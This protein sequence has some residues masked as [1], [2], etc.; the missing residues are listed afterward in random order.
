MDMS[1][2]LKLG[3]ALLINRLNKTPNIG[4]VVYF[5]YPLPDSG[6]VAPLFL[7]RCVALP[8]DSF[9]IID[10]VIWLNGKM[11]S[12]NFTSKENYYLKLDKCYPDSETV[13]R[14]RLKEGGS[15]SD[16]FDYSY[17]LTTMQVDSLKNYPYLKKIERKIEKPEI[18]DETIFPYTLNYKWNRDQF[19]ALYVPKKNDT[20][21]LDTLNIQLYET[22]ITRYEGH[23]LYLKTD[24][25]F[26]DSLY[27]QT[28]ICQQ[29]YFFVMGDNRDNAYD[30]RNW[31]FLPQAFIKGK[32]VKQLSGRSSVK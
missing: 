32:V 17:A 25:I 5:E 31:G 28:Y 8:G 23:T 13:K 3:D 29:N 9:K 22:L 20:L 27:T 24:S 26:I 14:F 18:P 6:E 19:G 4:D 10:K 7:Q 15:I 30:S 12:V 2:T 16:E 1:E 11:S 21:K